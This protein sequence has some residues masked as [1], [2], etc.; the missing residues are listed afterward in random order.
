MV[1]RGLGSSGTV[2]IVGSDS[3]AVITNG[4]LEGNITVD[5]VVGYSGYQDLD[6]LFVVGTLIRDDGFG[7]GIYVS[8]YRISS[9]PN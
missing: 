8:S 7:L 6:S 1:A 4:G 5:V 3:P 9:A 2:E